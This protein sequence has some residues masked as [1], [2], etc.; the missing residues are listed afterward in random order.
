MLLYQ[1]IINICSLFIWQLF[2]L[3]I[4]HFDLLRMSHNSTLIISIKK[5]D[6][7]LFESFENRRLQNLHERSQLCILTKST[8][9][10]QVFVGALL[11]SP[12]YL[13]M[14]F[15]GCVRSSPIQP[16]RIII[17]MLY[18]VHRFGT[19]WYNQSR[20]ERLCGRDW[21]CPG[22]N[23]PEYHDNV[24]G[25]GVSVRVTMSYCIVSW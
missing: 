17:I 14:K 12:W 13:I 20:E 3:V 7:V 15:I 6:K 8:R 4:F 11:L 25:R 24:C 18:F 23:H 10:W 5:Y 2:Y 21:A 1:S 22:E 19:A 9:S 16:H